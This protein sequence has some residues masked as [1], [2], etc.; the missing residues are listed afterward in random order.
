[1]NNVKCIHEPVNVFS[2]AQLQISGKVHN[3]EETIMIK[4]PHLKGNI[5]RKKN[6]K[7]K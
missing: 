7:F 1:M 3:E 6:N 5:I 2:M 4:D